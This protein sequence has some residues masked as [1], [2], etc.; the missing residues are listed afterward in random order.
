MLNF[1][2]LTNLLLPPS[3]CAQFS[4]R[5]VRPFASVMSI[6]NQEFGIGSKKIPIV[7]YQIGIWYLFLKFLGIFLVF[8]RYLEYGL[9][10]IWLIIGIFRQN[11]IGLV[12]G[13]CGCHF[14]GIGLVSIFHF[15]ENRISN[16][17]PRRSRPSA[18]LTA[19]ACWRLG[20]REVILERAAVKCHFVAPP[21]N[22]TYISILPYQRIAFNSLPA[23]TAGET[24]GGGRD[25]PPGP[26]NSI[27]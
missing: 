9:L 19:I 14:I 10:K 4:S 5:F 25:L 7:T 11:K 27:S 15:P 18:L 22:F 2:F 6:G 16:M 24:G 1:Y 26:I 12:F 23:S 3:L 21:P 17:H 13:F 20:R 8:H